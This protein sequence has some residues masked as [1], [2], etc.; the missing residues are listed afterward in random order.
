MRTR[1]LLLACWSVC[2]AFCM[3]AAGAE[4]P[5]TPWPAPTLS[6]EAGP[7]HFTSTQRGVFNGHKVAYSAAVDETIV[8]SAQGT[9][10]ASLFTIAYT[11]KPKG[12]E[13]RPVVF[14]YNGGPGGA[15]NTLHFGALGP[16]RMA[17]FSSEAQAD[18]ATPLVDNPHSILDVADLVFIDPP[19]TGYSR[20]LA[21]ADPNQFHSLDGDSYA[22][23]QLILRWLTDHD[24]MKSPK[25]LLGESYG[26]LRS[27]VLVRDLARA[28][29]AVAFDGVVF[30]SQAINYNGPA[31]LLWRSQAN[32]VAPIVRLPDYA[33]LAWYYGKIDN[34][35]QTLAQAVEKARVYARTRYAEALLL[36]N[37]LSADAR[38]G[39]AA[40]LE[41]LTGIPAAHYM[42][43]DLR[44]DD[45]RRE[46]LKSEG[47][48]LLQFDGRETEPAARSVPDEKRDWT[49]AMA[50]L[51]ANMERYSTDKLGVRG[52]GNYVSVV[53]D[54]YGYEEGWSYV[55]S[56]AP[57]LSV[58]LA[59]QMQAQPS[60]RLMVTQGIFDTTSSMGST[61]QTL[62]QLDVPRERI[63]LAYYPGGHML[64][65]DPEGLQR[66]TDD[67]RNFVSGKAVAGAAMPDVKPR[68]Q[69]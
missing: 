7:R 60:L 51:T 65:S 14:V 24:R 68:E 1:V 31:S 25:Y 59:R 27:V 48:V 56:P 22:L 35:S 57:P 61:E 30:V 38:L 49:A 46:L 21:G 10:A 34:H 19:D 4:P 40:D 58:Q 5:S 45:F 42:A 6:A 53:P 63:T 17:R 26:T 16:K 23:S 29:P 13:Q 15:S 9:P 8:K 2:A 62:A 33:A 39:V 47:Q 55:I 18:P 20:M 54:P 41:Q 12:D 69:R 36:G 66:F 64:Y 11:V 67:V 43:H 28:S 50:G 52:L 3:A 37:R 32:P 44:V